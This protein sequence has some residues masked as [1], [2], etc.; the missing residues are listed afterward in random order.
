MYGEVLVTPKGDGGFGY[1]PLFI[2][3]GFTKTLGE[4]NEEIKGKISHR[5]KALNHMKKLLAMQI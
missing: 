1:D 5:A 4:L 3:T 2:P